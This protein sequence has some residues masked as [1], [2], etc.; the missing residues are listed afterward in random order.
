MDFGLQ[1]TN[2][3]AHSVKWMLCVNMDFTKIQKK[4]KEYRELELC[5]FPF[6]LH[7]DSAKP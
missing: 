4:V 1:I 6:V 7:A 5:N 2:T 3:N